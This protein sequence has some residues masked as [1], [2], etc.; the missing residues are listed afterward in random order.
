MAVT[1]CGCTGCN[2]QR[3]RR[4]YREG[5]AAAEYINHVA[6]DLIDKM[7]RD[8]LLSPGMLI[9]TNPPL[10][11]YI[12]FTQR[13]YS[14][15]LRTADGCERTM[16]IPEPLPYIDVHILDELPPAV[17]ATSTA[18]PASVETRRR[19]F[20]RDRHLGSGKYLYIEDV[21]STDT[22]MIRG[23]RKSVIEKDKMLKRLRKEVREQD[24]A[25]AQANNRSRCFETRLVAQSKE[26]KELRSSAAYYRFK[27]A[28][29][30]KQIREAK[31]ALK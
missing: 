1:G 13:T 8:A 15:L 29:A 18:V 3:E 27:L 5:H 20:V 12:T 19:R 30:N 2:R 28:Q 21:R 25:L 16:S 26:V 11:N 23:F 24:V 9:M 6:G 10:P 14:A 17:M 31:R 4:A 22:V 7:M